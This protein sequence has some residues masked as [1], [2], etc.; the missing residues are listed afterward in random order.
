MEKLQEHLKGLTSEVDALLKS[1]PL[2]YLDDELS[3]KIKVAQN[4]LDFS[5][6]ESIEVKQQ[7]LNTALNA[8]ANYKR[9]V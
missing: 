1:I 8:I 4:S 9:T 5:N 7:K 6:N 2:N 3:D